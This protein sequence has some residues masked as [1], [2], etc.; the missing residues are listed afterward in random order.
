MQVASLA[1]DLPRY[2]TVVTEKIERARGLTLGRMSEM[3][4]RVGDQVR[5]SAETTAATP[6]ERAS[7]AA[8]PPSKAPAMTTAAGEE[9]PT[10]VLVQQPNP[11]P[12]EVAQ[13]IL[14][15]IAAPL[16]TTGVVFIVAIFILLERESLRDRMI[17]LFGAR[18]LHR[19]TAA[20]DDAAHRLSRYFLSQLAVNAAFGV[21]IAGGL[22][23][24]G[25][26]SPGLWGIVAALMRFVPYVGS[27]VAA[28]APLA[29]AAAVD[30]GWSMVA[31][32]VALFVVCEGLMGQAIEPILYG[33][34]T[35][36]APISIVIAA[37]FWTWLWGPIG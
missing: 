20:M 5:Q 35:G 7:G 28:A 23:A 15:P 26:P 33:H 31:W 12:L 25:V 32:T 18:D 21:V 2:A 36:L 8:R 22:L 24:I 13:R 4:G 37:I 9:R 6:G 10:P 16:A 27:F 3:I 17:R 1:D 30:P 14:S 29:L 11:T 19:T 34:S